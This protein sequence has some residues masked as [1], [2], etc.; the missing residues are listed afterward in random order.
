[1]AKFW[2]LS[3]TEENWDIAFKEN[4]WGARK[5]LKN[6]WQLLSPGDILGFYVTRPVSGIIG[7]GRLTR[8]AEEKTPYWPDEIR[9]KQ[10]IWPFRFYFDVIYRLPYPDWQKRRIFVRDLKLSYQAGINGL[11]NE[12][13]IASLFERAKMVWGKD[14]SSLA[15]V[16]V[17]EEKLKG[18]PQ[19]L[20]NEIRDKL[21]EIGKLR[22]KYPEIEFPMD[23]KR[24]DVIWKRIPGGHPI[25]AFEVQI[26]GDVTHALGKLKHAWDKWN[27]K[28][29]L[30]AEE[31]YRGEINSLLVGTF[32]EIQEEIKVIPV[33]KIES[34]YK[35][36]KEA[37]KHKEETGLI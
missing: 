36:E 17:K 29:Y 24:L 11:T 3:G 4:K 20:H 16:K 28:L 37:A 8:K 19:T 21:F 18:K 5:G 9:N 7:F 1:M 14:L 35:A 23:G 32:H 12:A 2:I 33:E 13:A 25:Y 10:A 6:R 34:L 30:I 15:R 22:K 26:G 27:S 31:K